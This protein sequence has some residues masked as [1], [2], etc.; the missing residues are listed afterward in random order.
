MAATKTTTVL[1]HKTIRA[2][3]LA[4]MNTAWAIGASVAASGLVT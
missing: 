3:L 1:L 4:L 2:L